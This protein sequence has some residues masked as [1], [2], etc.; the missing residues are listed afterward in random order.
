MDIRVSIIAFAEFDHL[1][2]VDCASAFSIINGAHFEIYLHVV[3][4]LTLSAINR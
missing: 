2:H 1:S 4:W 3:R